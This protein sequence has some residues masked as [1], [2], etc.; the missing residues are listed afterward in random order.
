L[1]AIFPVD[2]RAGEDSM[3]T[4]ATSTPRG[5]SLARPLE[6]AA[7]VAVCA[8]FLLY[9]VLSV[10][11]VTRWPATVA[12]TDF[13]FR[14]QEIQYV[15]RGID[16]RDVV[17]GVAPVDGAVGRPQFTY[18]PW[19]YVLGSVL[20]PPVPAAVALPWFAVLNFAGLA[21]L[22]AQAARLAVPFGAR[23]RVLLALAAVT[24]LAVPVTLRHLNYSIV[25]CAALALYVRCE[26]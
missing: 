6:T 3:S 20:V 7:L 1:G 10:L 11:Y 4:P 17:Q 14:W 25:L 18:P 26:E 2:R 9:A 13:F 21:F 19:S 22:A 8:A 12:G 5:T 23:A 15:F 24:S 16:P